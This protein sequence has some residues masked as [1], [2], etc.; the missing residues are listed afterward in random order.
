M[1]VNIRAVRAVRAGEA[2]GDGGAP[3]LWPELADEALYGLPGEIVRVIDPHTEADRVAV[4]ANLLTAFGSA[5]GR[6]AFFR[7]GPDQH[8]LK[9]NAALVGETAKGRKGT[10]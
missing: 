10:S 9:L 5:V 2:T 6:G 8:H 4:L 7:V 3:T 1:G